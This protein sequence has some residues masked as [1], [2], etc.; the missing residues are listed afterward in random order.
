MNAAAFAHH[1]EQG[2]WTA[3]DLDHRMAE[4]WFDPAGFLVLD[5]PDGEMAGFHWTKVHGGDG[6]ARGRS[7]ATSRSARCTSSASPRRTRASAW[8][9]R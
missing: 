2:Q 7:T 8:A 5:A 1:P 3:P 4:D 6:P 9:A